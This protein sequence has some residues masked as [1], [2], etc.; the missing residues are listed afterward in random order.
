MD[1]GLCNVSLCITYIY[2]YMYI[3][4]IFLDALYMHLSELW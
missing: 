4:V 1:D 3:Y 2:S